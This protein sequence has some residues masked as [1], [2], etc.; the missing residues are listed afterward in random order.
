MT[1]NTHCI[2]CKQPF[3]PDNVFTIEGARETTL[4]GMCE[5]C[6]DE[7]FEDFCDMEEDEE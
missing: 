7:L 5:V 3:S 4:S 2:S 1:N 6:W